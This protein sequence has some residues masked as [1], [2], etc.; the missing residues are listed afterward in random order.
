VKFQGVIKEIRVEL[1]NPTVG[2]WLQ[3]LAETQMKRHLSPRIPAYEVI[4]N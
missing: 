3:W 2:E 1:G 4:K